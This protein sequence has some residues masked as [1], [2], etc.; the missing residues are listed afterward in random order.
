M[1]DNIEM[2]VEERDWECRLNESVP[3]YGPLAVCC[4]QQ[5]NRGFHKTV[6]LCTGPG[7]PWSM[8]LYARTSQNINFVSYCLW[9]TASSTVIQFIFV[10]VG[11]MAKSVIK[12]CYGIMILWSVVREEGKTLHTV[13]WLWILLL[14]QKVDFWKEIWYQFPLSW[15]QF[16]S[17]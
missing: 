5:W 4:K 12:F 2:N 9:F 16:S 15:M 17:W 1:E 14:V 13:M 10:P 8:E 6:E 3:Q 11:G 7:G